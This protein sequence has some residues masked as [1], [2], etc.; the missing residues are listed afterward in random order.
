MWFGDLM[1]GIGYILILCIIASYGIDK[2]FETELIATEFEYIKRIRYRLREVH[3]YAPLGV[4]IVLWVLA[5]VTR[6]FNGL[7]SDLVIL[8][9]LGVAVGFASDNFFKTDIIPTTREYIGQS[10]SYLQEF[11]QYAPHGAA[12]ALWIL[13]FASGGFLA[14]IAVL[15]LMWVFWQKF[16]RH[17]GDQVVNRTIKMGDYLLPMNIHESK[18]VRFSEKQ[19]NQLQ[20]ASTGGILA[21][22]QTGSGKEEIGKHI[23]S[24]TDPEAADPI[25]IYDSDD[26]YQRFL[27]DLNKPYIRLSSSDSRY[28]W[29]LFREM[30]NEED[31]EEI[32]RTLF[33]VTNSQRPGA[34]RDISTSACQVFT[35]SL[36]YI[37]REHNS[38]KF[39]SRPCNADLV[40]FFEDSDQTTANKLLSQYTDLKGVASLID[41]NVTERATEIW[42]TLQQTVL[43]AFIGDFGA[44]PTEKDTV[45]SVRDYIANPQGIALVFDHSTRDRRN[46]QPIFQ[47]LIDLAAREA[48]KQRSSNQ[49]LLIF[50]E[51][52]QLPRVPHL[53]DLI[54]ASPKRGIQLFLTLRSIA[55]LRE[56]YGRDQALSLLSGLTTVIVLRLGDE[57]SIDYARAVI[58]TEFNEYTTHLDTRVY[59]AGAG[60]MTGT[61][62]VEKDREVQ[63][64][65]EHAFARGEF[66]RWNPC[67]GVVVRSDSWAFGQLVPLSQIPSATEEPPQ[68]TQT[69]DPVQ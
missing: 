11:H 1:K 44:K 34:N 42:T 64:K 63:Q 23:L 54:N 49:P 62:T 51:I 14:V 43:N 30:E 38:S 32:A 33:N 57:A 25:V 27:S 58:G 2:I 9:F 6:G 13:V 24:Q 59:G 36:K 21:L 68:Q 56:V 55:K 47:L 40:A 4:I 19:S 3:P 20:I 46:T 16:N 28:L 52:A 12:V 8:I 7:V 18:G 37:W 60:G 65:E 35:A 53:E 31:A 41:P 67:M 15:L 22:G 39:S 26:T 50:D 45:V 66:T 61:V 10:Y 29:N 5:V 69:H 17:L 48:L